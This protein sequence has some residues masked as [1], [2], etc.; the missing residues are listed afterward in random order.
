MKFR[1]TFPVILA[2]A[3]ALLASA[4]TKSSS[5]TEHVDNGWPV[6]VFV[7]DSYTQR[8]LQNARVTVW[9]TAGVPIYATTDQ[10]G[11]FTS[12]TVYQPSAPS[13]LNVFVQAGGIV[14]N[15][16]YHDFSGPVTFAEAYDSGEAKKV[17]AATIL[18][19]QSVAS[20]EGGQ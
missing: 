2:L 18:M 19:T 7:R 1:K 5:P 9:S 14:S 15:G 6:K 10:N 13:V 12:T 17:Y 4:C 16:S 3:V 11:T 20:K 8:A